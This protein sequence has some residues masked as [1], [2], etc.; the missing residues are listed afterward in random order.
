MADKFLFLVGPDGAV[1]DVTKLEYYSQGDE[2][3]V[4][5]Q[6]A[7]RQTDPKRPHYRGD[8]I[9]DEV[10]GERWNRRARIFEGHTIR[11]GTRKDRDE[12]IKNRPDPGYKDIAGK[13]V[14]VGSIVAV[15]F[16]LGRG[17]EIRIGRI[18]GFD[19]LLGSN[20]VDY[21]REGHINQD[22]QIVI[23]WLEGNA[24][25]G[26]RKLKGKETKIFAYLRRYVVIE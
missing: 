18:I 9:Y 15:A 7:Q 26:W 23:E 19:K 3:R 13:P 6:W 22:E 5:S 12:W 21:S 10:E 8:V 1:V 14:K 20:Y 11:L 2:E 17:A 4:P 16:A 24:L 25:D